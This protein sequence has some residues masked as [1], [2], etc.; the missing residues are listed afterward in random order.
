MVPSDVEGDGVMVVPGSSEVPF[1]SK[2]LGFPVPF[3]V[4]A[5]KVP[6]LIS[7]KR[8]RLRVQSSGAG[9]GLKSGFRYHCRVLERG[10]DLGQSLVFSTMGAIA[11][12]E[13]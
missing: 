10:D 8:D 7:L 2:S 13:A 5:L 12:F 11:T 6:D 1:N 4:A 3:F 9:E